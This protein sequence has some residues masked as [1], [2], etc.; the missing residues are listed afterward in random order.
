MT[1]LPV[2]APF[3]PCGVTSERPFFMALT[4]KVHTLHA[5]GCEGLYG[6]CTCGCLSIKV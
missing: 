2:H 3:K 5:G 4:A 6:Q 1:M